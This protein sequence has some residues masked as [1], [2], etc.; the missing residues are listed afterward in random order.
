MASKKPK[1]RSKPKKAPAKKRR[2]P[3]PP[4]TKITSYASRLV[5]VGVVKDFGG[6]EDSQLNGFTVWVGDYMPEHGVFDAAAAEERVP[7]LVGDSIFLKP[8]EIQ[9]LNTTTAKY[10]ADTLESYDDTVYPDDVYDL[11]DD[12]D[13]EGIH[14][15]AASVSKWTDAQRHKIRAYLRA[16]QAGTPTKKPGELL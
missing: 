8:E 11:R 3:R 9:P 1:K 16:L 6:E 5:R 14:V 7:F 13:V 12:L 10:I 4:I 15:T 2:T